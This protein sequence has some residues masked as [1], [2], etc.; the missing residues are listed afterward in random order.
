[1]QVIKENQMYCY[2]RIEMIGDGLS[3]SG[4]LNFMFLIQA[5]AHVQPPSGL[6]TWEQTESEKPRG[7]NR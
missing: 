2:P 4:K 3:V 6:T 5:L 1:M 7:N